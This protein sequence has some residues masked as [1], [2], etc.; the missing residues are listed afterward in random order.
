L[1][2]RNF[3]L[4]W[5]GQVISTIGD[6]VF[7]TTVLLWI[8]QRLARG[9]TWVP[10]AVSGE[11]IAVALPTVLFGPFAGVFVDRWDKRR[12]MLRMDLIR[13]VLLTALLPLATPVAA[14]LILPW[15]L[16]VLYAAL[17][18][19]ITCSQF[20]GPARLSLIGDLVPSDQ[21]A[22]AASLIFMTLSVGIVIGPPVA[23]GLFFA[24][25]PAWALVIDALSFFISFLAIR[26]I[27]S[28]TACREQSAHPTEQP[29]VSQF[30]GEFLTG[31]RYF[32]S[33]RILR[34]VAIVT[35]ITLLGATAINT[36]G[37][38]FLT[39]NL[40]SPPQWYGLLETATG[41][42]VLAGSFAA[43]WVVPRLG[44]ARSFWLCTAVT[45]LLLMLYARQTSYTVALALLVA[46]GLP[47]AGLN[48]AI[49]PLLLLATPPQMVG[50]IVAQLA[51]ITNLAALLS[52][53]F[54]GYLAT[55]VLRHFHMRL[56]NIGFGP[57]DTM[58]LLGGFVIACSSVYAWAGLR[59]RA[60]VPSPHPVTR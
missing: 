4:L 45:G 25:G 8:T 32:W 10:L 13:G 40:R 54:V 24:A 23:A 3:A 52:T 31:A 36:L 18:L 56:L 33:N 27:R 42:G 50:R 41:V 38:F 28:S 34:T 46:I 26:L 44:V 5:S 15:R 37:I 1:I 20:F 30:L 35:S 51:P 7:T 2:N 29:A 39:S 49:G 60:G 48:V 59:V 43:T 47:S 21:Q 12:T 58:Y 9:Q 6:Y 19:V 17:A 53:A 22:R 57:Y 14:F 16:G 55:T 11:L